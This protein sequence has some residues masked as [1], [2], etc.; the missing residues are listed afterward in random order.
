MNY[1]FSEKMKI[2]K[3]FENTW[4]K[5][6]RGK[7]DLVARVF[8]TNENGVGSK[9]NLKSIIFQDLTYLRYLIGEW[10]KMKEWHFG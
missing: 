5:S 10:K 7:K 4:L 2:E 9:T 6:A 8:A 3:F 1:K